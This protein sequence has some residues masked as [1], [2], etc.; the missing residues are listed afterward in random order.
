M[1]NGDAP[2]SAG[3]A[4]A[5][6]VALIGALLAVGVLTIING[7]WFGLIGVAGAVALVPSLLRA[8]DG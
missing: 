7:S 3:T 6:L 4:V 5:V 1:S 8:R 2:T